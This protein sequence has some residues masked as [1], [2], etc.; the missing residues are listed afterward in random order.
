MEPLK[1]NIGLSILII[2][3]VIAVTGLLIG[4]T[5]VRISL[6]DRKKFREVRRK[7]LKEITITIQEFKETLRNQNIHQI[8]KNLDSAVAISKRKIDD[9]ASQIKSQIQSII[10]QNE[11]SEPI[12]QA[13]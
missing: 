13:S 5:S 1:R 3:S 9:I 6:T 12:N 4:K 2:S 8:E 10:V 7:A 11:S